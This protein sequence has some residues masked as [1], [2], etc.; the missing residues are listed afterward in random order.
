MLAPAVSLF[1]IA[2]LAAACSSRPSVTTT[3]TSPSTTSTTPGSTSSSSTSSSTSSTVASVASCLS[4]AL[5][6]A[7]DQAH[8]TAGAGKTYLAISVAN[9]G[10]TTCKVSGTPTVEFLAAPAPGSSVGKPITMSVTAQLGGPGAVVL[11]PGAKAGFFIVYSDVPVNGG[12]CVGIGSLAVEIPGTS[13]PLSLAT[14]FTAC[15]GVAV[16]PLNP[17]A[18]LA[19]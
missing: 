7:E 18:A 17:L 6:L 10:K 16:Y 13:A 15:S 12:T 19:P 11:A 1:A 3:T 5:A 4:S 14:S 9:A 2:L 8:S